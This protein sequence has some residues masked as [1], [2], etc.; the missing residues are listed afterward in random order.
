[1]DDNP[2]SPNQND[3]AVAG[4]VSAAPVP[5]KLEKMIEAV[6][7]P[8]QHVFREIVR[9]FMGV[10]HS[11]TM[12]PFDINP[13]VVKI[14]AESQTKDNDNKFEFAKQRQKDV[15]TENQRDYDLKKLKYTNKM[16]LLRPICLVVVAVYTICLF[17]GIYL[18]VIGKETLGASIITGVIA[19]VLSLLAGLGLAPITK[20]E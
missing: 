6:P 14:L 7:E 17:I 1:M 4:E 18:A 11:K 3:D 16:Q 20:D 2:H 5:E 15:A 10:F 19:S 13:E 9:E 12:S 8:Q